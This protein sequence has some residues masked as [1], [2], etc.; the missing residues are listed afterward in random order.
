MRLTEWPTDVAYLDKEDIHL[1]A[2]KTHPWQ[3][4]QGQKYNLTDK[5]DW[6]SL[7]QP[8]MQCFH[9]VELNYIKGGGKYGKGY[10]KASYTISENDPWFWCHFLGDPVMPGSQGQDGFAQLGGMWAAGSCQVTGRGRA[11]SGAFEYYGQV[12]P[13]AKKI[14]FHLDVKRFLKKKKVVFFDGYMSVDT[15]ENRVYEF[16]EHKVGFFTREELGIPNGTTSAYYNPEWDKVRS[17]AE[18]WIEDA[19]KFYDENK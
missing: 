16:G 5:G 10:A 9:E 15:P 2:T 18:S 17:N 1:I 4:D 11:L 6:F 14:I 13:T 8:Y 19:K 12:L 3:I 7:P